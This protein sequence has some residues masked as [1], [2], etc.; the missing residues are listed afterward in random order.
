MALSFAHTRMR[1]AE[2][3]GPMQCSGPLSRRFFD[4]APRRRRHGKAA[5]LHHADAGR[6]ARNDRRA[7]TARSRS[8]SR[9]HRRHRLRL[10]R[11]PRRSPG[12]G[13]EARHPLQA[14][15]E[16]EA[17][18]RQEALSPALSS[19][20]LF[21]RPKAL[22][23]DRDSSMWNCSSVVITGMTRRGECPRRLLKNSSARSPRLASCQSPCVI[24]PLSLGRREGSSP[25]SL[26]V[27]PRPFL[28]FRVFPSWNGPI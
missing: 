14:R 15:A 5:D 7:G 19:G 24:A 23:R 11:V 17:S 18:T 4:Q 3:G 10:K 27:G 26:S 12:Q 9:S 13:H 8:R 6:A 28:W 25:S 21:P 1:R 20:T 2:K 16:E 22:S